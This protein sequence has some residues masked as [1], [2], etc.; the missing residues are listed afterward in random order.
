M[1][2]DKIK[3]QL[4]DA[5]GYVSAA[6]LRKISEELKSEILAFEI[7]NIASNASLQERIHWILTDR[8]DYPKCKNCGDNCVSFRSINGIGYE[9]TICSRAC[10]YEM[11]AK[12][13]KPKIIISNEQKLINAE[14]RKRK[15]IASIQSAFGVDYPMQSSDVRRKMLNTRLRNWFERRI[16]SCSA[17][18]SPL[19]TFEEYKY[20]KSLHPWECKTCATIFNDTIANGSNPRCPKCFPASVSKP[21]QEI[22]NFIQS[23]LDETLL[24][25]DR[26]IIYP[27]ELDIVIPSKKLSIE[28]NGVY[29]HSEKSQ[30]FENNHLQKKQ[31]LAKEVGYDVIFILDSE[32]YYH[33]ELVKSRIRSKLGKCKT[34][35]ARK[36]NINLVPH[37]VAKSFIQN[38]HIQGKDNA[39]IYLGLYHTNI[40][41][42]IMS[43]GKSRYNK[44]FEWEL[45]RYCTT[46]NYSITGGAQKLL[47]YFENTFL[48]K[49][50]ITYSDN[51]WNTGN[52]YNHLG[53]N[54]DGETG[55][56]YCYVDNRGN[57]HSRQ[58]MQKHK[59]MTKLENY[60]SD[61]TAHQNLQQ[62]GYYRLWNAGNKRWIKTYSLHSQRLLS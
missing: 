62:H 59:L 55:L 26:R 44:N 41:M 13:K 6:K 7:S 3:L 57:M 48:P 52:L 5:K 39:T 46:Q 21:Q 23:E 27:L 40:L 38:N 2:K 28:V 17:I 30:T 60:N 36:C 12:T 49:S 14:D 18:A 53:F 47:K 15:H 61:L 31:K 8:K 29:W 33:Q 45:L 34:I 10:Q 1:I 4:F 32:W 43:F 24:I 50:I 19:F 54:Y 11:R 51:R 42:A 56:G 20:S 16:E 22:I 25:N 35:M 58:S 37:Q 9:S